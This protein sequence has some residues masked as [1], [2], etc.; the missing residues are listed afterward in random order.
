MGLL[1]DISTKVLFEKSVNQFCSTHPQIF[2]SLCQR[3]HQGVNGAI[4]C[5]G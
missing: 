1:L 2:F 4:V 3:A 5:L